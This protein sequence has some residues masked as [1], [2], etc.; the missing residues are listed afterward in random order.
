MGSRARAQARAG[1]FGVNHMAQLDA[2]NLR[3]L[4]LLQEDARASVTD[5]ARAVDRAEST[6]RERL[7]ALE[8]DGV[9]LGYRA[10]IDP[11]KLGF[12][13][14][15]IARAGCDRRSVPE[16]ARRLAAIPYVVR[17]DMVS[18][19]KPLLVELV[20]D[21]LTRLERVLEERL[22]PLELEGLELDIVLRPLVPPRP[23]PTVGAPGPPAPAPRPHPVALAPP[24]LDAGEPRLLLPGAR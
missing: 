24:A 2:T 7:A 15:A 3:L 19:P 9:L 4:A 10:L 17:V 18:G 5:L 20:A 1:N 13:I 12:Q 11:A 14:R 16:V 6:V 21:S 8:R 22:A 23:P